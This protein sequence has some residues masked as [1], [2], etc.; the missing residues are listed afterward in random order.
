MS[1]IL[2]PMLLLVAVAIA[3][4]QG[5]QEKPKDKQA[6]A[7]ALRD[8]QT[9]L[10]D[11]DFEAGI[12]AFRK[13]TELDPA[14][15]R[16]WQL[17]GYCLHAQ[18]RLDEA[19]PIHLKAAE[20]KEVAP[21]A[22]YNVACV[23]SLK[24]DKDKAIEWLQKAIAL[25]FND[26]AQLAGDTD[27]DGMRD[28]PRLQKLAANLGTGVQVFQPTTNRHSARL[29]YFGGKG[30]PGQIA[31]DYAVLE[32]QDRFEQALASPK[33]VGKKWR[34]GSDFWTTM[35]NSMPLRIGGV[36]IP[37]GYWYLTL[38]H[39]GEHKFVLGVHDP[40]E[41][42]KLHVDPFR[43]ELVT[44]GIE[45]P[46]HYMAAKEPH[47]ELEIGISMP[48]GEQQKGTFAVGFGGHELSADVVVDLKPAAR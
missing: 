38:E 31:I 41:V 7:A 5:A 9:A 25:G 35:D 27:F 4:A 36:E 46:L 13:V 47:K 19:L 6:V 18:K 20:F 37:A 28:D 48:L 26:A 2:A 10:A 11:S 3:P 33:F 45:V 12:A 43:A 30:S 14:N 16:G 15:A 21:V 32:W 1:R 22:T 24:G 34:F 44:G 23:Y 8:G 29:A 17:L 42:R 39:R 40:V